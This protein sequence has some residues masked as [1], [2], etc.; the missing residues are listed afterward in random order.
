MISPVHYKYK[1]MLCVLQGHAEAISHIYVAENET[2]D[3]QYSRNLECWIYRNIFVFS[4]FALRKYI[5]LQINEF[6]WLLNSTIQ[7]KF[8]SKYFLEVR[9]Y[10]LANIYVYIF[11]QL[12]PFFY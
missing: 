5:D 12:V 4:I 3:K 6:T 11:L 2:I 1:N 9:K 8:E 10:L 7:G